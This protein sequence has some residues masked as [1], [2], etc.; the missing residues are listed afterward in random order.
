MSPPLSHECNARATGGV[1]AIPDE[2]DATASNEDAGGRIHLRERSPRDGGTA[3]SPGQPAMSA[4]FFSRFHCLI[5]CS[6]ESAALFEGAGSTW[7][8]ASTP[9]IFV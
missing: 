3:D 7:T 9:F 5:S 1:A 6:R 2:A 8:I 4:S